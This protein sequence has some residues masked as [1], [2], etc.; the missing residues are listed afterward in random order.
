[1]L[2]RYVRDVTSKTS[3]RRRI[4]SRS[5]ISIKRQIEGANCPSKYQAHAPEVVL[6]FDSEY[7]IRLNC[8]NGFER[9]MGNI[10][11]NIIETTDAA[12]GFG[13]T[14]TMSAGDV[15][16]GTLAGD[17]DAIDTVLVDLEAGTEY[18]ITLN[19]LQGGLNTGFFGV[20]NFDAG[21]LFEFVNYATGVNAGTIG[22]TVEAG[23]GYF[24]LT[25]TA[26]IDGTFAL[27]IGD[28]GD[29][30]AETYNVSVF[31]TAAIATPSVATPFD[32]DFLAHVGGSYV[33]LL[34][35]NDRFTGLGGN[36]YAE[37]MDGND[38]LDGGFGDDYLSGGSGEDLLFG[39]AGMDFL[40]GDVDNDTIFGGD[41]ADAL[42]GDGGDDVMQGQGGNDTMSGGQGADKL[43]GGDGDDEISGGAADDL[44]RGD[45]GNDSLSG[46]GGNDF[47]NGG[48]DNDTLYGGGDDDTLVGGSGDDFL[49][50]Q[51]GVDRMTGGAGADVFM[52]DRVSTDLVRD[53]EDGID[54]IQLSHLS[55]S[56]TYS[57]TSKGNGD[58]VI[59]LDGVDALIL[60]NV[61]QAEITAADIDAGHLILV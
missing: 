7:S 59:Q 10:M 1:M 49:F 33:N 56:S 31:E 36:D 5:G 4:S 61:T 54:M 9:L 32:D 52:A 21:I 20:S 39:G 35:G 51:T 16:G 8:V 28:N 60:R 18:S 55:L 37:G 42:D 12:S 48:A 29:P 41:G 45:D 19:G 6:S 34:D 46:Q 3:Q 11:T 23:K 57:I 24:T 30:F 15:F 13:T 44:L 2:L 38:T 47:L 40:F 27:Q 22:G 50:G 14:Y 58:A 17:P 43:H 25:F 26:P 53:F